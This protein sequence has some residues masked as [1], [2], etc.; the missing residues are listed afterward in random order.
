M[1]KQCDFS[2]FS[3][4]LPADVFHLTLEINKSGGQCVII[5]GWL[6]DRLLSI[7]ISPIADIDIEV[8]GLPYDQLHA[9]LL[10]YKIENCYPKFGIVKLR[11]MDFSLPR[12]EIFIGKKYNDFLI[13]LNPNLT[14]EQAARRRDF[15]VNAIGWNPLT[16]KIF[17]PFNGISAVQKKQLN[18]ITEHFKEDSYRV[19]RAVQFIAKYNFSPSSLLIGYAKDMNPK[20]ISKTHI[21]K[22]REILHTAK[23]KKA[24]IHFLELIGDGW[25]NLL[26]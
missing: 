19:L 5:G 23:H 8:F 10:N 14:F 9:T 22:T 15:S 17:D 24:A 18:P 12:T 1:K 3:N 16:N 13:T 25:K 21:H 6:R 7:P 20:F 2:A 4:L 26:L 11:H